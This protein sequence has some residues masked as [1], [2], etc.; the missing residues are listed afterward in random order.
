MALFAGRPARRPPGD[1]MAYTESED[2]DR[3][4][5]ALLD[6]LTRLGEANLLISDGLELNEVLQKVLDSA[7]ALTGARYGVL[8][9][10]DDAGRMDDFL[11][12][13]LSPEEA[14]Q[15]WE[16]PGGPEL[17]EYVNAIGEPW[18]VADFAGHV[19]ALGLPELAPPTPMSSFMVVPIRHRNHRVGSIH[20]AHGDPGPEFSREDEETLVM[21]AAPAALAIANAR[22]HREERRARAAL[23]TLV[24]TAPVGVVVFDARTGAP[25]SFNR[26]ALRIVEGMMDA[27]QRPEEFLETLTCRRADGQE[28]SLQEWPLAEMMSAGE[29]VRAEEITLSVPDGRSVAALLNATPIRDQ[30]GAVES[31]V[32]TLQDLTPLDEQAR[33]RADFLGMVSHELRAP[34]TSILGSATTVLN[35][36]SELDPAELGQFQRIIIDQAET[37]R[38]LI[39]DLLDVA[40]IETGTLPAS[41]EPTEVTA[42]V[43][44]ARNTFISGGGGNVLEIELEP[45]LPPVMADRRRIVQVIVNLLSNAARHSPEAS[46]IRVA[47]AR[48]GGQVAISVSDAGRGIPAEQLPGLFRRFEGSGSDHRGGDTGLGLVVCKGIVEAHGGRIRAESGGPGLGARF[49]FTLPTAVEA[50]A[51][52]LS[53]RGRPR[54]GERQDDQP[55]LVVDDDPQTL[56]QVR[57]ILSEAGYRPIVTAEPQEVLRLVAEER[58]HLILLDM[59]LPGADGIELMRDLSAVSRAPVVFLS[60]YGG[61]QVI[62]RALEMGAVDYI[63]KPFSPTEL[64]A[65]IGVAL[66]M[67]AGPNWTEPSEPYVRGDLTVDYAQRRVTRSGR[68]VKLTAKEYDLLRALSINA[69]RT[70]THEQVLQQVWEPGKGD[71]RGLRSLLLRL[72]RKLG[73]DAGD[74][75]WIFAVP[76]VGY[77]MAE[78]DAPQPGAD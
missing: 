63:V 25:A 52:V 72:R 15:L 74:P 69:G 76:Q 36:A 70:L 6:R 40:R 41:P 66:R 59:M 35:A 75:T 30:D 13:G 58:P 8:T 26:E 7:R 32:V 34:L 22:Q 57:N 2:R 45:D 68:G 49:A 21:F 53:R 19:R 60:A 65:R 39:G 9:T 71:M 61:D 50:A 17:F 54:R 33:L 37:M 46:P 73:E 67:S 42:L 38:N 43:D 55:V 47:A 4:A 24:E 5:P 56:W 78:A 18:R 1:E 10:L 77:R 31:F 14:Q 62:A 3:Q 44:R 64:V 12:S 23:E 29:T 28:V 11:A 20:I 48:E 27:D 51:P 16:M